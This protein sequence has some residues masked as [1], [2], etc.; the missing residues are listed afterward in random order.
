MFSI[1]DYYLDINK[2]LDL[3]KDRYDKIYDLY[4]SLVVS[5][6]EKDNDIAQ[7]HFNTL[8][9]SGYLK[10]KTEEDRS[11]KIEQING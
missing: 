9:K 2:L 3:E 1:K 4:F 6:K 7:L 11:D 8:I 10:N 5:I